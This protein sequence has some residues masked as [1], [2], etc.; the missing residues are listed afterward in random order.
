MRLADLAPRYDLVIIGGGITGAG[1]FR[2]ASR[3]GVSVLLV[4]ARD[5]ASGTSSWSSKL[6]HGGLRYLQ[7]GEWRLTAESVRE[8][9]RLLR[10]APD[11][12][13]RLDFL[14][15]CYRGVKPS[16]ALVR[17]GLWLYDRFARDAAAR[18]QSLDVAAS[19][20]IT[21]QLSTHNLQGAL[22]YQDA[23]TDDCRLVWR[24]IE[25]GQRDGGT[26]LNYVR[27]EQLLQAQGR[28]CGVVLRDAETSEM[29]EVAATVV[30]NASGVWAEGLQG[31]G[32]T[33]PK[34]RPL[35][36]S[37]LIYPHAHLPLP[38]AV[39]FFHPRDRRPVFAYPWQGATLIGTTDLD[40]REDLWS[41]RMT[42]PE[43][44][45]LLEA[46]DWLMPSVGLR[47]DEAL[48]CFAGVRAIVDDGDGKPSSAS[49][50]SA[51]WTA[52]GFIGITGGKLTTFRLTARQVL[53]TAAKQ[54]PGLRHVENGAPLFDRKHEESPSLVPTMQQVQARAGEQLHH[55]D[56]LLLRRSRA[57]LVLP[58]FAEALIEPALAA[59]RSTL[60]WG[61]ARCTQE[62]D[63]Y[64][65][66]MRQ[67][68]SVP[69][70]H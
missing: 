7:T 61:D 9:Q 29:R 46:F 49:R 25:Q 10:E 50:E 69:A 43:A 54:L 62:A 42:K 5:F 51:Q 47:L 40:H 38:C 55:L 52:P 70:S 41:P 13:E 21:P 27:A 12:V 39:S 68:H 63:R 36:G 45:Y 35:R 60:G 58:D 48:S 14:L 34:L 11:L 22:Q 20:A 32:I 16:R 33:A 23:R 19:L 37:H 26:A 6:V 4:E 1:I 59:C 2:E 57:G 64:R 53:M 44:D 15:P 8:R 17:M 67:Q 31:Q 56:D 28:T 66:H 3:A 30:I 65:S 18:S 24:L